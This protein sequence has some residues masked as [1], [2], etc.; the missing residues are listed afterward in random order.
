MRS[1]EFT[2]GIDKTQYING[3]QIHVQST[4]SEEPQI[5]PG[6]TALHEAKHAVVAIRNGT[7][8]KNVTITPGPG[9]LGL[10][11]LTRPDP[12]A[13]AAPHADGCSGT[14]HDVHII[15]IMGAD[16]GASSKV[17]AGI[18]AS[19][20]EEIKA[21]A[22]LLE[23]KRTLSGGDIDETIKAVQNKKNGQTEALI[24][25]KAPDEKEQTLK[26]SVK[27]GKV[28]LPGKWIAL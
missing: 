8:V 17:A 5:T 21:V 27:N 11:E 13:A 9:Y 10:T 25:I 26:S 22:S 12:V 3:Y 6:T 4:K 28:M 20:R 15:A 1:P 23:A 2:I 24:I 14:D 19:N 18:T 7:G 16:L